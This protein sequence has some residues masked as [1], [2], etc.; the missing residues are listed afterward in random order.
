MKY[1]IL[2]TTFALGGLTVTAAPLEQAASAPAPVTWNDKHV[3]VEETL[4]QEVSSPS[5][6][7]SEES[8]EKRQLD[9]GSLIDGLVPPLL[10]ED[11]LEKRQPRHEDKAS[12]E[13]TNPKAPLQK[14]QADPSLLQMF[15]PDRIL[16]YLRS[17]N[18]PRQPNLLDILIGDLSGVVPAVTGLLDGV[19]DLLLPPLPTPVVPRPAEPSVFR[20]YAPEQVLSALSSLGY[21]G[22]TG[23]GLATT[24]VCGATATIPV[25]GVPI[26]TYP[27]VTKTVTVTVGPVP[28]IVQ[29]LTALEG[30]VSSVLNEIIPTELLPGVTIA[31]SAD[32]PL[33]LNPALSLTIPGFPLPPLGQPTLPLITLPLPTVTLSRP[34]IPPLVLP[35]VPSIQ[36]PSVSLPSVSLPPLPSLSLPSIQLP[37][38]VVPTLPSLSLPTLPPLSLPTLPPLSLPTLPPFPTLPSVQLPTVSLP[39]V[40]LPSVSL[41]SASLPSVSLPSVSLPSVSLPSV[42]IPSISLPSVSLPSVSLPSVSLPSVSLPSV[43]LPSV[44]LPSVSLPSVS[45]PSVSIPSISL[46]S[47]SIPSV[48]LPSVSLPSVSL[49]S[50]SLPS[51]ALPT[52]TLPTLSLPSV[53]PPSVA[54]PT[55]SLPSLSLPSLA[56]PTVSL[57]SLSLPSIALPTLSLPSLSLPSVS[58]PSLPLPSL[59]LPTVSLPSLS[60]PSVALP[61]L[62]ATLLPEVTIPGTRLPG[63]TLSAPPGLTLSVGGISAN[64]PVVGTVGIPPVINLTIKPSGLTAQG[65]AIPTVVI[66][67]LVIPSPVQAI[68]PNLLSQ[69]SQAVATQTALV[70]GLIGAING[71]IPIPTPIITRNI[72][73]NI[74]IPTGAPVLPSLLSEIGA[75]VN[76]LPSAVPSLLSSLEELL[77]PEPTFSILPFPPFPNPS[78]QLPS[79]SILPVPP[80]ATLLPN[81]PVLTPI[82][83]LSIS[84]R[85]PPFINLGPPIVTNPIASI[86]PLPTSPALPTIRPYRFNAMSNSNVAVYW[87]QSSASERVSLAATCADPNVDMVILGFVTDISYQNSGLPKLTLAPIIQGV[88]TPY[89]R[90]LSPG[91]SYYAQLEA[92][93]KTCQATHGKKVLLSIGGGGSQLQ[94][95]SET[96]AQQ[97][98][99]RLWQLFGPVTPVTTR[100]HEYVNGLR[101]FGTAVLDGFDLAKVD[102]SPAY[103]GTFA[104]RL[105]ANFLYDI[106]KEYYLSAAPGCTAPD[107]SIPIGYLAQCN[108]IWPRFFGDETGRC[109]I[110]G[111]DFLT[112]I[113][114][115]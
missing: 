111:D 9:I 101:P 79:F 61:T 3:V 51:I 29:G 92:D 5:D 67:P 7:A 98:A 75:A 10:P 96:E 33:G 34:T 83:T 24:T 54:L 6:D 80:I 15:T 37:S 28:I 108:F 58:L 20:P 31:A 87:G 85:P 18:Q 90:L 22:G 70:P 102:E 42:S 74:P 81:P 106:T 57:P 115:W 11:Q 110:G 114:H 95:R 17:L 40:S 55:V 113:L 60:L 100:G 41:P 77:L 52:V 30:A 93:I 43:S 66:P 109:E 65:L 76:A 78:I 49:P 99:N 21:A 105:R 68:L 59:A 23:L 104:A 2:Y 103:W 38:V 26:V 82:P 73:S 46:P 71:L 4:D 47:V 19:L 45:L 84:T 27:I 39:S 56:L 69:L 64:L 14:R 112:S 91:L 89:Q 63:L 1:F 53:S 107:R 72:G 62:P 48:S 35:P 50:V 86:L 36:L 8:L 94:L 97:F 44:S 16:E 32:L 25:A 13:T 88:Q 12:S